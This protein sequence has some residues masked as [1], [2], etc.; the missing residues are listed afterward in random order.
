MSLNFILVKIHSTSL[1]SLFLRK[2]FH[3]LYTEISFQ[4]SQHSCLYLTSSTREKVKIITANR[5]G[6][7]TSEVF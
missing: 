3:N 1:R 5:N 4:I 7:A 2:Y 6:V